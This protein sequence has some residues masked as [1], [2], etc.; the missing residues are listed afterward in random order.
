VLATLGA[1]VAFVVALPQTIPP[2][3][4]DARAAV[5]PTAVLSG[6]VVSDDSE[7]RPV[8][9]ARVTCA[10][11]AIRTELTTVTDDLGRFT[12]AGLPAGRYTIRVTKAGWVPAMYGAKGPLRSGTPVALGDGQTLGIIARLPR[13][14][15]ITGTVI[16]ES[17]QPS[18]NTTVRAMRFTMQNGERRLVT[19]GSSG[20]TDDRGVYRI[21]SLP[22]GDFIIGA[23]ARSTAVSPPVAEVRMTTDLDLH[24]ARTAAMDVPAPPDRGVAF[25]STFFPGTPLASQASRIALRT[26]EERG[27]IDFALQLVA[28][29]RVE[30]AVYSPEGSVPPGTQVV[31]LA[32][33]QTAFPDV[34]F[35]GVRSTSV[36]ADSAFSFS[37]VSPGQYTLLARPPAPLAQWASTEILVDGERVSGVSLSLQPGL[38]LAGNVSFEGNR[39]RPPADLTMVRISLRP[40][41]PAGMVTIAPPEV[42]ADPTGHFVVSGITPGW[43][44]L[45]ATIPGAAR[46][47]GAPASSSGGWHLRSAA[48]GS[49]D[50]L[51]LPFALQ[52]GRPLPA[53]RILFTDRMATLNG[54]LSLS[55]TEA[56]ALGYTVV[57]FPADPSLWQPGSRRID[58]APASANGIFAFRELAAGEYLLA[59]VD[60]VEPGEWFDRA[61]LQ[62]IAPAAVRITIGEAE[63]KT[64]DLRIRRD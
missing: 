5:R 43:Y 3:V 4:R 44:E 9:H 17:G 42:S 2:A 13:G 1:I 32:S 55:P 35:D 18:V 25:A 23:A 6:T 47:A 61:F 60:D 36:G 28:T 8:R 31:M 21:F 53:A 56:A 26:G 34:P 29:A 15:V 37:S 41:Q 11:G 14:A 33:G 49:Q 64:Q 12:F 7:A 10:G 20:I 24:H 50:T 40:V 27:G 62:R 19:F 59:A 39:L 48:I 16:D 63:E 38:T 52:P 51:D 22:P 30:G 57:L 45:R 54:A 58:A 46:P